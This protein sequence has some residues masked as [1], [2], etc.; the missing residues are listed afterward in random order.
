M[1]RVR[2]SEQSP[3]WRGRQLYSRALQHETAHVIA[4]VAVADAGRTPVCPAKPA[5]NPPQSERGIHG[6]VGGRWVERRRHTFR[7]RRRGGE[8][9]GEVRAWRQIENAV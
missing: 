6:A 5:L 9:A 4:V 7:K 8:K 2:K 1:E 3:V